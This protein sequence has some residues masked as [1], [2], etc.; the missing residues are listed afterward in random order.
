MKEIIGVANYSAIELDKF[1]QK[2]GIKTR[3]FCMDGKA[4]IGVRRLNAKHS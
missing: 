2:L 1:F 4:I 3:F